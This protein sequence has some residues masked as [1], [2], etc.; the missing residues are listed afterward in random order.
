MS[1]VILLLTRLFKE[2]LEF[3]KALINKHIFS[4]CFIIWETF[5]FGV[6]PISHW[7]K[8]DCII[9]VKKKKVHM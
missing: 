2:M 9:Q 8:N 4:T 1:P 7:T 5:N 6:H 3:I